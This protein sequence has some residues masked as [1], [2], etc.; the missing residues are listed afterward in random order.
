[1]EN[2]ENNNIEELDDQVEGTETEDEETEESGVDV[3]GIASLALMVVGGLVL[4]KKTIKGGLKLAN[5]IGGKIKDK[6]QKKEAQPEPA[7]APKKD[8]KK[9]EEETNEE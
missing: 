5:W 6:K 8:E 7:E 1:M 3:K 2:Y 4:A 9:P